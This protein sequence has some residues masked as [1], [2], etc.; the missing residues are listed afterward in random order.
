MTRAPSTDGRRT[1]GSRAAASA[2]GARSSPPPARCST[3]AA[4]ATRRSRTS[5]SAVGD[6]PGDRLP[7]LHRQGGAVRAHP[8]RLPRRAREALADAA[9]AR[10][11]HH[12]TSS[13]AVVEAFVDYGLEHPAF[14]DCAQTLM[15]RP[16]PELLDEISE[17][18]LFRLGRGISRC[19]THA[20]RRAR[21]RRRDRRLH[22]RGPHPAGQH[23]LRQR[24]R[25]PPAR[26][27]RHPGQGGRARHPRPVGEQSRA[28]AG[29][30][31]TLVRVGAG[32]RDPPSVRAR[33]AATSPGSR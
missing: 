1:A 23:A 7:P 24:P 11:R 5:R 4:C 17:S 13:A 30:R 29:P 33:L 6:Q 14:V 2:R 20:Q 32:A 28:D 21:G 31:S 19:L 18:A 27:G 25:R 22:G 3:S 15:R 10:Q 26:P 8:G 16:G 9:G 12:P